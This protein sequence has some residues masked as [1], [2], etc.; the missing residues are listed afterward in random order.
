VSSHMGTGV[1]ESSGTGSS[2]TVKPGLTETEAPG[3]DPEAAAA[4]AEAA[5]AALVALPAVHEWDGQA[6]PVTT[7]PRDAYAL[8]L[9][10]GRKLYDGGSVTERSPSLTPLVSPIELLVHRVDRERIGV[11]DGAGVRMT[12]SRG[13]VTLPLRADD[14][15]PQGVAFLAFGPGEPGAADLIDLD[16]PVTDLR[17]ETIR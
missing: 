15:V 6:A 8:R 9:V 11:P 13:T 4:L 17:V 5:R 12:S 3:A 1:V 14:S 10:S 2:T 7:E 16:A